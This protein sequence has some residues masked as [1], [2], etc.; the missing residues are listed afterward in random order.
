MLLYK[1]KSLLVSHTALLVLDGRGSHETNRASYACSCMSRPRPRPARG[2]PS[3]DDI[4][5]RCAERTA[6]DA[7]LRTHTSTLRSKT[8]EAPPLLWDYMRSRRKALVQRPRHLPSLPCNYPLV[9]GTSAHTYL[10]STSQFSD[11]VGPQ[12]IPQA[13]CCR[14]SWLVVIQRSAEIQDMEIPLVGMLATSGSVLMLVLVVTGAVCNVLLSRLSCYL[15]A[16]R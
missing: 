2:I 12:P 11:I 9:C 3:V 4:P 5:S 1:G 8:L 6:S 15:C 14:E 10:R 13:D 7:G 16:R